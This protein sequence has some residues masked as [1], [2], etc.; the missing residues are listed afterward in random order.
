MTTPTAIDPRGDPEK[1]LV[2]VAALISCPRKRDDR[3]FREH[4]IGLVHAYRDSG[5]K[6]PVGFMDIHNCR[7]PL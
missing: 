3:H 2:E 5:H 4:F 7:R 6:A 1:V